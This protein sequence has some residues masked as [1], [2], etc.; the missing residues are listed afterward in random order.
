M[1]VIDM[2]ATISTSLKYQN[3]ICV[4]GGAIVSIIIAAFTSTVEKEMRHI[5]RISDF[6][7]F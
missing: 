5:V 3:T 1:I 7:A 6:T 2:G 4:I